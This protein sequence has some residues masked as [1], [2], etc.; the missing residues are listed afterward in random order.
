MSRFVVSAK[1]LTSGGMSVSTR[2]RMS[3]A[4]TAHRQ[5][6]V[7]RVDGV[8]DVVELLVELGGEGVQLAEQSPDLVRL[9]R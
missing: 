1:Y 7:G 2:S 9:A 5:Q 6:P 3:V 8:G 4:A